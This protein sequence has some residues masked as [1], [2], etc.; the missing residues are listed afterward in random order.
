MSLCAA[1]A[2]GSDLGGLTG[3][4]AATTEGGQPSPGG[5]GCCDAIREATD[6]RDSGRPL[7]WWRNE[8]SC[9]SAKSTKVEHPWE[10]C[11]RGIEARIV[12][13]HGVASSFLREVGAPVSLS[14]GDGRR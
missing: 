13:S 4:G 1:D 14:P 10:P 11:P 8:C 12:D 7:C 5:Y 9:H 2:E 6:Q 3:A